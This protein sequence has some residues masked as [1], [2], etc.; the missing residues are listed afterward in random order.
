MIRWRSLLPLFFYYLLLLSATIIYYLF[1]P[2]NYSSTHARY[3]AL[4][5][6]GSF[7][8]SRGR[9]IEFFLSDSAR[10]ENVFAIGRMISGMAMM[11]VE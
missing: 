5:R 7:W 8:R 1:V 4:S 11:I 3:R 9:K 2:R 6:N 10:K